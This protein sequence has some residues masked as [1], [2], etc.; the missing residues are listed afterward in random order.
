MNQMLKNDSLPLIFN[1]KPENI[2]N[3]KIVPGYISSDDLDRQVENRRKTVAD[4]VR[5]TLIQVPDAFLNEGLAKAPV[6]PDGNPLLMLGSMDRTLPAAFKCKFY[7][8]WGNIKL[9]SDVTGAEIDTLRIKL[10]TWTRQSY[11]D[12]ILFSQRDSLIRQYKQNVV[13]Q[14]SAEAA[15]KKRNYLSARN[16]EYLNIYNESEMAKMNDSIRFALHYLTDRAA[17][18]STLLTLSNLSGEKAKIWTAN[19]PM[20]P[21]R[22][23]LKNAQ[24]DSLS[25]ILYN[26]GKG[27]L[28]MVIDDGVKLLRFTETQKKEISFKPKSPDGKLHQIHFR[29]ID[30]LPW[31]VFGTGTIGFS[32]TAL[33]NWAK[34]GESSLSLLVIGRYTANYTKKNLKWENLAEFRIGF[35]SSKLRGLEKK[36]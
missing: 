9:P 22:I 27:G 33:S 17:N 34:G 19:H 11:N 13:D 6:I 8:G 30:P 28:R 31:K 25:V 24:N 10:F 16:R 2:P 4:S 5:R 18:D 12:S 36:R 14:L 23:F 32:Q 20:R 3:K 1:R 35:F 29:Q 26:N 7:K 15:T 21:M